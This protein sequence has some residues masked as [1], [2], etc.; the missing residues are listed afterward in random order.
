MS[1]RIKGKEEKI[2]SLIA[3]TILWMDLANLLA[4]HYTVIYIEIHFDNWHFVC[5]AVII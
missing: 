5:I 3:Q 1:R 4:S 2:I